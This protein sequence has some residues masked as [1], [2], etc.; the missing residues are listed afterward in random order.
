MQEREPKYPVPPLGTFELNG[1]KVEVLDFI[2]R[3]D[4][5]HGELLDIIHMNADEVI[6]FISGTSSVPQELRKIA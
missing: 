3:F 6:R 2:Q 5:T 4:L 1:E